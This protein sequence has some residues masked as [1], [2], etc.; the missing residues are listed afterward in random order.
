MFIDAAIGSRLLTMSVDSTADSTGRMAGKWLPVSRAKPIGDLS[1]KQ[2]HNELHNMTFI[3]KFLYKL[4]LF[5]SY[6]RMQEG[7]SFKKANR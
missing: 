7:D 2:T 3:C 6:T 4:I 5:E 1:E